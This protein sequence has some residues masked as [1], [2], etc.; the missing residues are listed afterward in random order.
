MLGRPI[1]M[2]ACRHRVDRFQFSSPNRDPLGEVMAGWPGQPL[3]DSV[4]ED[5][6]HALRYGDRAA[7]SRRFWISFDQLSADLGDGA[8]DADAPGFKIDVFDAQA[9][10][11]SESQ[12]GVGQQC[13][14]VALSAAS[15]G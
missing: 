4:R 12:T 8:P 6:H 9:D 7:T 1:S 2:I 15:G 13:D 14:D 5:R 11:L 3:T 10:Q